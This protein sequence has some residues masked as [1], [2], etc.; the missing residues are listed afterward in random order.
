MD[1]RERLQ[2]ALRTWRAGAKTPKLAKPPPTRCPKK[3]AAASTRRTGWR[4]WTTSRSAST[5]WPTT[6]PAFRVETIVESNGWGSVAKRDDVGLARGRSDNFFS[7]LQI[8]VSPYSKYHVLDVV[9]K[10]TIRNKEVFSRNFY[11][12]LNEV[13][14]ERFRELIEQWVLEYAEMYAAAI[15][16]SGCRVA[17][18]ERQRA[19]RSFVTG[20]SVR[21][22]NL[23]D[24]AAYNSEWRPARQDR[25]RRHRK[26]DRESIA[27]SCQFHLH[28]AD[29]AMAHR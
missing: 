23:R 29:R 22:L 13:D 20:W 26:A 10:G 4:C 16:R 27:I 9:A 5:T 21:K 7:R 3:N 28:R 8:V 14:L 12:P 18:V 19:P 1:F 11:Q 17:G 24:I 6:S 2:R 15:K 25:G